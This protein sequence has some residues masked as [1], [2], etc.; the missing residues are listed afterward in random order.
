ML[1]GSCSHFSWPTSTALAGGSA[2]LDELHTL[3]SSSMEVMALTFSW[4]GGHAAAR[5]NG[6]G[7]GWLIPIRVC[8]A[9]HKSQFSHKKGKK[10]A[11]C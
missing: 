3:E 9:T 6:S 10:Q 7:A 2:G 8:E 1:V 11:H 5:R 4:T